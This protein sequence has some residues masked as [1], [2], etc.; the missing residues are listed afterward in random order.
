MNRVPYLCLR[1]VL[2]QRHRVPRDL[3]DKIWFIPPECKVEAPIW[4][5][6]KIPT[7]ELYIKWK[8]IHVSHY[9]MWINF[10]RVLC[11]YC[12]REMS[13]HVYDK[14]Y[15]YIN[16]TDEVCITC[17]NAYLDMERREQEQE[18]EENTLL[19]NP[20]KKRRTK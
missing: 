10:N 17:Y 4:E 16:E 18:R 2:F 5:S 12:A 3:C 15:N 8:G 9:I 6:V 14:D 19:L 7:Y 11:F 1:K 20:K 13:S